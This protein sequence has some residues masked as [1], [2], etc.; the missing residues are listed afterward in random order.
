[1]V[2]RRRNAQCQARLLT[3]SQVGGKQELGQRTGV[4]GGALQHESGGRFGEKGL[5]EALKIEA[6]P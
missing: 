1:M 6:D 5:L 4:I 3:L 2:K